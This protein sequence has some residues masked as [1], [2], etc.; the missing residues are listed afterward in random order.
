MNDRDI[1]KFRAYLWGIAFGLL[2]W[3]GTAWVAVLLFRLA[4]RMING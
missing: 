3:A 2:F 4:K 1:R